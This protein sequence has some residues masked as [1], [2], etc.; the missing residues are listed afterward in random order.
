M[1]TKQWNNIIC[2][3]YNYVNLPNEFRK[4]L[5]RVNI[6]NNCISTYQQQRII[7]WKFK[8]IVFSMNPE[9]Y[10]KDCKPQPNYISKEYKIE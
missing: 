6:K 10:K 3:K 9:L 2:R 1:E 5:G 8:K 4:F 7:K